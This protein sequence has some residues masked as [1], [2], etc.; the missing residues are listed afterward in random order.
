MEE[1]EK[2]PLP[3]PEGEEV[4]P[5]RRISRRGIVGAGLALLAGAAAVGIAVESSRGKP[6]SPRGAPK[7]QPPRY[8]STKLTVPK[9]TAWKRGT[10]AAGLIFVTPRDKN[11]KGLIMDEM[12]EP[13]WIEPTNSNVT[14]LRVQLLDGKPV[15]TYWSGKNLG[16]YGEGT[17]AI[18][19]TSYRT[20]GR[21]TAG[22]GLKADLHEF[23]LT[24]NRT[25]LLIAYPIV[26]RDLTPLGG[27]ADGYIYNCHVQE[28]DIATGAVLLDWSAMDHVELTETYLG[29]KQDK[30]HDG[31]SASA[32]FDPFHTNGV[33]EDGDRLLLSF[34]HT[35][36]IYSIDRKTGSVVWRLGGRKSDFVL[37]DD[38]VFAWQHDVRRQPDG[39][40]SLFDNHFYSGTDGVSRGMFFVLDEATKTATNTASFTSAKHLGTAMGSFQVLDNGNVLVGWG[41]DPTVT[42]FAADGRAV[43]QAD[44]GGIAYRAYKSGWKASPTTAP[45]IAVR[46]ADGGNMRVYASWNGATEVARWRI[47]SG[48][49]GQSLA[50]IATIDR[51]GF[52]TVAMVPAASWVAVQA[53]DSSDA[54]LA[55]SDTHPT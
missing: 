28:V 13:V 17:G 43:Y 33:S 26:R 45:D 29:L 42:E 54:V 15:L 31:T 52:E 16:G 5:S 25:A 50:P 46:A 18:L 27:P 55:T 36:A 2:L 37:D 41:T 12:G 14:D 9:T 8:L 1:D 39:S 23:G 4:A 7:P 6:S 11:F 10:T 20:I 3:A 19:D 48:D 53:L 34:R 47:L 21:V 49:T 24:V 38:A 44:L 22:N 51:S 40:I 35:H 30:G 32:A